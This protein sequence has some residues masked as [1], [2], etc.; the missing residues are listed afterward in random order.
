MQPFL[1]RRTALA[2]ITSSVGLAALNPMRVSAQDAYPSRTVSIVSPVGGNVEVHAR[3]LAQ[4]L[5]KRLNGT[6]IVEQKF[7]AGGT[8]GATYLA[9]A[10]PDGYTIGVPS[11]G[12]LTV[13]PHLQPPAYDPLGFTFLGMVQ[14]WRNFLL[15]SATSGINSVADLVAAAR[16]KPGSLSF[17]SAGVGTGLHLFAEQMS[18]AA[19]ISTLHV[20]YKDYSQVFPNLMNGDIAYVFNSVQGSM[21]L[22]RAGK[23]KAIA[24]NGDQR[25]PEFPNVPTLREQGINIFTP[26]SFTA[27]VGPA[28]MPRAISDR[29]IQGLRDI[30]GSEQYHAS[31]RAAGAEPAAVFGEDLKRYVSDEHRAWG[32]VIKRLGIK[33]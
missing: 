24:V 23:L 32:T 28:N 9:K 15:V 33:T 14:T 5:A 13:G 27:L 2:A 11:T 21:E 30:A 12:L 7:G 6:F 20:P 8:I 10:K 17:A 16:A 18:A 26:P 19:G 31:L 3:Y 25:L 22:V 4:E 29:L 1:N